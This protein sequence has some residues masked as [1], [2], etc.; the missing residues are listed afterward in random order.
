[1]FYAPMTHSRARS[2]T[3][4]PMR[5]AFFTLLVLLALC[6]SL[7]AQ[8]GVL[9]LQAA[10]DRTVYNSNVIPTVYVEAKI[11]TP[12]QPASDGCSVRNI[13]L[14]LDRSGSMAGEPIQAL[15]QAVSSAL[16]AL[17]E[18]D[19]VSIVLFGSEV[20]TLLDAR[21]RDQIG[22]LDTLLARIEPAGGAALY[23]ALNQGAAQ[24]RRYAATST[25]NHLVLVT[26]GPATK[27]P[28]ER[29]D[30]LRLAELFARECITL[31]SIGL[32][33]EFEEDLLAGL[34]RTGNGRF[35]FAARPVELAGVLQAEI[36]RLRTPLAQDVAL[37]IE[38]YYGAEEIET[39]GWEIGEID[40]RTVTFRLPN[41]FAGQDVSVMAGAVLAMHGDPCPVATVRLRWK[42][43]ATGAVHETERRL[44]IY[45]DSSGWASR[46]SINRDVIRAAVGA[47]ISE[48][49]Q[50]A[51]EQLDK[52][53]IQRALRELRRGRD[54][55]RYM[56]SDL[57]DEAIA[58]R[59]QVLE[60]YLSDVQ[61][62]GLNQLDRKILRSGLRN[63][64]EIPT[65]E[66]KEK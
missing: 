66:P 5:N 44:T 54:K 49:M 32:G 14:V 58:S 40:K 6:G 65:E 9:A 16:G 45:F 48:G 13:A 36:A 21:R 15:R 12:A 61:A 60:A 23:D 52:G 42:D 63:Q 31:S 22:D 33:A 43:V 64:F 53:D 25:I 38:F 7:R 34:A 4:L 59:I 11:V 35:H 39:V 28:R 3:L 62:R 26:D 1:M 50:S 37:S 46:K 27:G 47:V 30:F 24:L 10:T 18:R 17:A 57:E 19:V 41:V 51:I 8:D 2:C 56:N 55:A 29:D 20:E